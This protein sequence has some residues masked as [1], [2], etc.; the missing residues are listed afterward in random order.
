[1]NETIGLVFIVIGIAF[2]FFGSL[3]LLRLPDVYNRL[4]AAIKC[5]TLGTSSILLDRKS[6]V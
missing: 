2:D 4:H 5:V 6:V 1:M 3:G